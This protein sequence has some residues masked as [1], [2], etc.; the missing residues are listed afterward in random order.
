VHPLIQLILIVVSLF[1]VGQVVSN[2]FTKNKLKT[3]SPLLFPAI[4][5]A[6]VSTEIHL[7]NEFGLNGL[8]NTKFIL[9]PAVL[10][11]FLLSAIALL[12][13]LRVKNLVFFIPFTIAT[14]PLLKFSWSWMATSNDD[15]ANY[16]LGA[17]YFLNNSLKETA[18]TAINSRN[19]SEFYGERFTIFH[20]RTG[21][22]EFLSATSFL[23]G[24][25]TLAS[26]MPTICGL[27]IILILTTLTL[28]SNQTRKNPIKKFFLL[29]LLASSPLTLAGINF[30]LLSQF[31][32]LVL[33]ITLL[34]IYKSY[35]STQD[36]DQPQRFVILGSLT[37]NSAIVWYPEL[38]GLFLIS[39]VIHCLIFQ[40]IKQVKNLK[41]VFISIVGITILVAREN[42]I[43]SVLFARSQLLSAGSATINPD[44]STLFPFFLVPHGAP[45]LL[46]FSTIY[47]E[48]RPV[49]ENLLIILAFILISWLIV[50]IYR[51]RRNL[52]ITEI[53]LIVFASISLFL[54]IRGNFYSLFKIAMYIQPLLILCI[55]ENFSRTAKNQKKIKPLHGILPTI[56]V[57]TN[58]LNGSTSIYEYAGWYGKTSTT[59][60]GISQGRLPEKINS[61][62]KN[63]NPN[64][65]YISN[66][67]NI[68]LAKILMSQ[69]NGRSI[70]FTSR[71]FLNN[72]DNT[73][74]DNYE[75][76][77]FKTIDGKINS[78]EIPQLS[79]NNVEYVN[80][81]F[82]ENILNVDSL[83]KK[84]WDISTSTEPLEILNFINSDKGKHYYL[85]KNYESLGLYQIEPDP[86]FRNHYLNA[87]G[88][89][90]L[91]QD[92]RP[93]LKKRLILNMT[94]S[95]NAG[96]K[97]IPN[98]NVFGTT[99][100]KLVVPGEGSFRVQ[101]ATLAPQFIEG[102]Y[103]Y[104]IV[105]NGPL[106][107]FSN[108]NSGLSK[109]YGSKI[110]LDY[111]KV[112]IFAR[113][114]Y[115]T[116]RKLL[117]PTSI[118]NFPTD[119]SNP[120]L[121]Y[122]GIYEDGWLSGSASFELRKTPSTKLR[123]VI[124]N[125]SK[126]SFEL[127]IKVEQTRQKYLLLNGTN[128]IIFTLPKSS[129]EEIYRVE[130][131]SNKKTVVSQI[132]QRFSIGR[133]VYLGPEDTK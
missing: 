107:T 11:C 16:V 64:T 45:S 70:N 44:N 124:E 67:S 111:R 92:N 119:L 52:E 105:M 129:P 62:F 83:A 17:K 77:Q 82:T 88:N 131:T 75:K 113:G 58:F 24:G 48:A 133:L 125:Q 26:Y 21:A 78:F 110:P 89:V 74:L 99:E 108:T 55:F 14:W 34:S 10:G 122:S 29:L 130:I 95:F 35:F 23:Q 100:D 127:T 69:A 114:I 97:K 76:A 1:S 115:A 18:D 53:A 80:L 38:V 4:G 31:G 32:G 40:K 63:S 71:N 12:K 22:E 60:P 72:P 118:S 56:F 104:Q 47:K 79:K 126:K 112:S 25:N 121:M 7:A 96:D 19:Y 90:L 2:L 73:G 15:M 46:G 86:I 8:Q 36:F 20:Y 85:P 132:D 13:T 27:W 51:K 37:L 50:Q 49:I 117:P 41:I 68:V 91:I 123:I 33:G 94:S 66:T 9:I 28:A 93:D 54:L 5:L 6:T 98:I 103:Y 59:I 61:F 65:Q 42:L 87:L 101:T 106:I 57:I 102:N 120:D 30:Q 84:D 43:D 109:L 81:G 3:H 116:D 39:I 128:E